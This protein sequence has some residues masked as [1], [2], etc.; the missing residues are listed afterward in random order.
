MSPLPALAPEIVKGDVLLLDSK[1][2]QHVL[3]SLSHHRRPAH[4]VFAVFRIRVVLQIVFKH[5]AVNKARIPLPVIFLERVGESDVKREVLVIR[6]EFLK[7]F[8]IEHLPQ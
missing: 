7:L 1:I 6:R 4:V 5:H 2:F 8:G 3:H